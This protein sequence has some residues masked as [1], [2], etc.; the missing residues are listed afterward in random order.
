MSK[1]VIPLTTTQQIVQMI[2]PFGSEENKFKRNYSNKN[3]AEGLIGSNVLSR[4]KL[5]VIINPLYLKIHEC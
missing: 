3:D 2:L 1:H 5:S 4:D